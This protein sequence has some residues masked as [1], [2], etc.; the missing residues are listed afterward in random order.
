MHFYFG[1]QGCQS[2]SLSQLEVPFWHFKFANLS[3]LLPQSALLFLLSLPCSIFVRCMYFRAL[4]CIQIVFLLAPTRMGEDRMIRNKNTFSEAFSAAGR[5]NFR[6][7]QALKNLNGCKD[8]KKIL[9][10]QIYE[11]KNGPFVN[12]Y[13]IFVNLSHIQKKQSVLNFL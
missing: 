12:L 5:P 10:P 6:V 9:Y 7:F 8:I 11:M 2:N 13:R 1:S 3:V 4:I